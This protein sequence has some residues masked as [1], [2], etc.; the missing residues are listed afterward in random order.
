MPVT[1][2]AVPSRLSRL[3]LQAIGGGLT[4]VLL[5][6]AGLSILLAAAESFALSAHQ[7]TALID[8]TFGV[9][10]LLCAGLTYLFRVP[11]VLGLDVTGVLFAVSLATT[12]S[13]PEVLGGL[14]VAGVLVTFIAAL[15]F[16]SRLSTLI[17]AP[18]IFGTVAGAVMPFVV[19]IFTD[20]NET[21]AMIGLTVGAY[22]LARRFLPARIPAILPALAVGLI[23]AGLRGTLHGIDGWT[24]PT[25]T[26]MA[27]AFSWQAVL[28]IAPVMT[29]LIVANANLV[30]I[31][32]LR[33]EGY[34]HPN[35]RYMP[36]LVSRPS[37]GRWWGRSQSAWE[38]GR[39]R[40]WLAR[41]LAHA[42]N[43]TGP[44]T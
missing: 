41:R 32:Y 5:H 33:S 43:A 1:T 44:G 18:I 35:G 16:S 14:L 34:P 37:S 24:F 28:S 12:Y 23:V 31:V 11:L 10:A 2:A 36:L 42:G 19:G 20:T 27:P 39:W 21:P 3:P 4:V 13:Y 7:T 9:T 29:V 15:G 8:G 40:L 22:L 17:P 25:I 30:G 26:M 38:H 6:V